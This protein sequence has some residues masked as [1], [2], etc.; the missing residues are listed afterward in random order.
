MIKYQGKKRLY[1]FLVSH[2]YEVPKMKE[3]EYTFYHGREWLKD[4][5]NEIELYAESSLSIYVTTFY[6]RLDGKIAGDEHI[7]YFDGKIIYKSI[8]GKNVLCR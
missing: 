7:H 2:G 3:M 1:E 6:E 5:H 8:R 4:R